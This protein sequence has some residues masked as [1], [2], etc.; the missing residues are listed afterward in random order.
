MLIDKLR[1]IPRKGIALATVSTPQDEEI[2]Y[3]YLVPYIFFF[4]LSY[5][6]SLTTH[7]T[8]VYYANCYKLRIKIS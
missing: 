8:V 1:I 2:E 4:L 5:K 3:R 6:Y 7:P